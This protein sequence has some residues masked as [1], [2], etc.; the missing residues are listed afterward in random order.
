M[1]NTIIE[2]QLIRQADLYKMLDDYYTEKGW[3][4]NGTPT[5]TK[6]IQLGTKE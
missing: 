4:I 6:L 3:D 1:I 5:P 2:G